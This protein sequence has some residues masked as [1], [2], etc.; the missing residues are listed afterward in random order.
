MNPTIQVSNDKLVSSGLVLEH[1][2]SQ[3]PTSLVIHDSGFDRPVFLIVLAWL[4]TG[5]SNLTPQKAAIYWQQLDALAQ[6]FDPPLV[7]VGT[8]PDVETFQD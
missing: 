1:L 3:F 5:Q 8:Y 4:H 7:I 2:K 6:S